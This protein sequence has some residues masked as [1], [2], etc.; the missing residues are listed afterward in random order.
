MSIMSRI[1]LSGRD[2]SPL[3]ADRP[4]RPVL[5]EARPGHIPL[6][7]DEMA[8]DTKSCTAPGVEEP[9]DLCPAVETDHEV[10]LLEHAIRFVE[11]RY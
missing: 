6:A 4:A 8:S 3:P 5:E 10:I 1:G 11:R 7:E 2:G 9:V